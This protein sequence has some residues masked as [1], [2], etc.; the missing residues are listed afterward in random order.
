VRRLVSLINHGHFNLNGRR[1]S[2]P[3]M[4]VSP[5]DEIAVRENARSVKVFED[6]PN[7]IVSEL[8][9]V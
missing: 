5:G 3:S 9:D 2:I 8:D 7:T 4:T 6:L 1:A